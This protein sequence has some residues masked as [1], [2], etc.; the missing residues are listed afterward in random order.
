MLHDGVQE[1]SQWR[2]FTPG[3]AR[4]RHDAPPTGCVDLRLYGAH[5]AV[6]AMMPPSHENGPEIVSFQNEKDLFAPNETSGVVLASCT[7]VLSCVVEERRRCG[8]LRAGGVART[9]RLFSRNDSSL[10]VKTALDSEKTKKHIF[11]KKTEK[12]RKKR[13][14]KG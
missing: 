6:S 9:S 12:W 1:K 10:T 8:A 11:S 3:C 2:C 7:C 14:K 5:S 13:R 4:S